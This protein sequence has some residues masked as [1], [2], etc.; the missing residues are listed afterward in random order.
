MLMQKVGEVDFDFSDEC[1]EGLPMHLAYEPVDTSVTAALKDEDETD[2]PEQEAEAE[3][4]VTSPFANDEEED[5]DSLEQEAVQ[6]TVTF[7]PGQLGLSYTDEE[8]TEVTE[9]GQA[10][11]AGVEV[12]WQIVGIN[13]EECDSFGDERVFA[14]AK[15]DAPFTMTF[16]KVELPKTLPLT[17]EAV[18]GVLNEIRPY[19]KNDGGDVKLK[20]IEGAKVIVELQGNCVGCPSSAMTMKM[21]VETNLKKVIPEIEEV[22]QVVPETEKLSEEAVDVVLEEV[23]PFIT[24]ADKN[25]VLEVASIE[26]PDIAPVVKLRLTSNIG[27]VKS[28]KV[29]IASRIQRKFANPGMK[30]EWS[31]E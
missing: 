4:D 3:G 22:L 28:V 20:G 11:R 7:Q 21:G 26:G 23:R 1:D 8:V 13:G 2:S 14:A 19:L 29:E 25:A 12:G 9:D 6:I 31:G 10:D 30:I 27:V 24:M 16:N 17:V 18:E 5:T 15:G